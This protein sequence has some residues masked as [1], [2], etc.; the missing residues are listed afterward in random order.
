MPFLARCRLNMAALLRSARVL[1]LSPASLLHVGRASLSG[2]PLGRL[3]G[4]AVGRRGAAFRPVETP[5]LHSFTARSALRHFALAAKEQGVSSSDDGGPVARISQAH[6]ADWALD[7]LDRSVRRTGRITKQLLLRVFRDICRGHPSGNQALLLLRSCGSLLS[8][9]NLPERSALAHQI[10]DKLQELGV[11]Y[12]ASHYN[13]LLKVYLQNSFKFSPT[14]FLAKMEAA[15]VQPNRVTYQRL[16]AAYCQEGDIEGA[17]KILGFMK[18]K[19]IPITE[20]VFNS[21]LTG[22]ARAG[23]IASAENMLPLMKGS[24]IEPGPDT[25]VALLSAHA[26]KGDVEKMTQIFEEVASADIQLMDRD[27]LQV[28]TSLAEAGHHQHVPVILERMRQEHGFVQE[29][30]NVCLSLVTQGKEDVA[31]SLLNTFPVR[32]LD[33][34]SE[35]APNQG[36]FFLRHCVAMEMPVE[37]LLRYCKD[38]KESNRHAAPLQFVLQCALASAKTGMAAQLMKVM[39]E[40]G[41]PVREHFFWPL[42]IPLQQEKNTQGILDVV[43]IMLDLGVS[44]DTPTYSSYILPAFPSLDSARSALK[45]VGCDLNTL[46]FTTAEVRAE[47]GLGNLASLYSV[48]SSPSFLGLNMKTFRAKLIQGFIRSDDVEN[49][50]KITELLQYDERFI[51]ETPRHTDAVPY[52]LYNLIEG[53]STEEIQ[54]K[55][56]LLREYF[57]QLRNVISIPVTIF[58]GIR[59]LLQMHNTPELVKDVIPLVDRKTVDLSSIPLS[60]NVGMG[61]FVCIQDPEQKI[62]ALESKLEDLKSRDQPIAAVLK[63]LLVAL[64][65]EEKLDQALDVKARHESEMVVGGYAV[66]I[67]LCCTHDKVEEALNLKRELDRRDSSDVL[68]ASKYLHL[69]KAL[70]KHGRLEEAVDMLK[71]MKGKN[72]TLEDTA[73]TALFHILNRV[74]L[75]G[76]AAAVKRLQDTVFS[77]GLVKPSALLASPIATA[78]LHSGD[79]TGGLDAVLSFYKQYKFLPRFHDLLCHLVEKEET[80]LLQK[81]MDFVSQERGEMTMLYD[82]LFAFLQ[83]GRYKEAHKIIETPGLRAK[84]G[85]LQW[86][87]EKC[88]ANEQMEPLETLVEMTQKLFECDRDEMYHYVLRLCDETN[89][90]R[91]AEA[92][93]T[94]MQEENVIPRERTLRLLAKILKTNGQKVPFE[95]PETWYTNVNSTNRQGEEQRVQPSE[96]KGQRSSPQSTTSSKAGVNS[97]QSRILSLSKSRDGSTEAYTLLKEAEQSGEVF[98][99]NVYLAVIR[100]LLANGRLEEAFEVRDTAEKSI[101]DFGLCNVSNGLLVITQVKHGKLK[102][103]RATLAAML[104]AQQVPSQLSITRLVQSLAAAGDVEAIREVEDLT[105]ETSSLIG[106]SRMLFINNVVLAHIKNGDIQT[107][108]EKLESLYTPGLEGQGDSQPT[109]ISYVFRKVLEDKNDEA[110]DKL[111]AMAERMANHFASYRPVTSLFL[112]YL[113]LGHIEE[114]KSQLQRVAAIAEQKKTLSAFLARMSQKPGQVHAMKSLLELLPD[115]LQKEHVYPLLMKSYTIDKDLDRAKA[116]HA[117]MQTDGIRAD[118]LSLKRLALLYKQA[119]EPVPFE[120]PPES[121]RFYA[122]KLRAEKQ[123][124]DEEE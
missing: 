43:K 19:E 49:M 10:W 17:S 105:K 50:V 13:A 119:G 71:E 100:A 81:A 113:E 111:S 124:P 1:K 121:F 55:E 38:L 59:N 37:K 122:E 41:L 64:C 42:L 67:Q 18:D 9:V 22:H 66:L 65:S 48:L 53:M 108:V 11:T 32:Q 91:K 68:T 29:A 84:S 79:L 107:A 52:F 110:L 15:N 8:E 109:S 94:K 33:S 12:D 56:K 87:A 85:R 70:T 90:W 72:L 36:N 101:K 20:A 58:R 83:T 80:D 46:R 5:L 97:Y 47:A 63:Q 74:A 102:D 116:L 106:L 57:H 95:V 27:F 23:D 60:A 112:T 104:Q 30:M 35:T 82:L 88:I 16:I 93:W 28:L 6:R 2:A 34:Q 118:E 78:Y 14:D 31:F 92:A 25:Y 7:L 40:E 123:K 39:K 77:L 61:D 73:V 103:A 21:L 86:F 51:K 44:P 45:E 62:E 3:C 115:I 120:E 24:G 76:D 54:A 4:G 114:A 99:G 98:K 26:E 89:D 96:T 69:V 75:Q 117:Q